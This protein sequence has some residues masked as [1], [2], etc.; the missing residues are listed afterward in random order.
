MEAIPNVVHSN[1]SPNLVH[2]ILEGLSNSTQHGNLMLEVMK[3]T[4][5]ELCK[6]EAVPEA[7]AGAIV[8]VISIKVREMNSSDMAE[9]LQLCVNFIQSGGNLKKKCVF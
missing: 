6:S 4:L 8:R 3:S 2:I 7:S 5:T 9:L 1:G